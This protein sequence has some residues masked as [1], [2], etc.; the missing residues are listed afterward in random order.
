MD[1]LEWT[2]EELQDLEA[3]SLE[4]AARLT[5][6]GASKDVAKLSAVSTESKKKNSPSPTSR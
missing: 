3:A 2:D 1:N 6:Q 5:A 4:V